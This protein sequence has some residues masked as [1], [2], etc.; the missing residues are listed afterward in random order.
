MMQEGQINVQSENIFPIIKKFLYSDNDIFLR[1]LISNAVDATEKVRKLARTGQLGGEL[2]D[3]KIEVKLD[4]E[5]KTLTISDRGVGMTQEEVEKYINQIAFSG[6]EEFAKKLEEQ[7]EKADIIGQ[8]GLGFYSAFM[9]SNK[10]EIHS[11]SYQDGAQPVYWECDGSTN[12]KIGEGERQDRGTDIVLHIDEENEEFLEENRISELLDKYCKFLPVPIKFGTKEVTKEGQEDKEESEK[13]KETVDNIINNPEPAWTKDPKELG[14]EDYKNFYRELY[15][16][17]F[18][19]PLFHIHLNVDHP[20]QLTGILYFPPLKNNLE[21]QKNRIQLYS[22]QVFV[23]DNVEQIVPEFLTLLHGVIDSPDI[24]LNVSRSYLQNDANV[25]KIS[26]HITKKVADKL[27][28]MFKNDREDFEKKWD[29][30]KVFIQYGILTDDKF[31]DRVKDVM[32]LKNIEGKYFTLDEYKDKV[33]DHQTDKNDKMVFLYTHDKDEQYNF[34]QPAQERGYDVLLMDSP[35]ASHLTTRLE[36]KEENISFARVD[37]D[38]VDN[39]IQKEESQES[40]LSEE[41][42]NEIKPVFEEQVPSENYQVQFQ[43][44]SEKDDPVVITQSEF[45]RRMKEQQATGGGGMM[46]Q[47]PEM[48]N[49]V[50]NANHPLVSRLL[51]EQDEEKK[52]EMAKQAID[53]GKLS[54]GLLKGEE[55]NRFIKRS[56]DLIGVNTPGDNG[57]GQN[58]Q[59]GNGQQKKEQEEEKEGV[60][61]EGQE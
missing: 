51:K 56:V 40:K 59:S 53:L 20:F 44:M 5:N 35:L 39:L 36:Q 3:D 16:T 47:L 23:T 30:I 54:Q 29:D 55:L 17:S 26:G 52:K 21:V 58:Q 9:V 7:G 2:G 43:P 28:E 32:L 14:E 38:T 49:L 24:P 37:A 22:N 60:K 13:E 27:K 1:E 31:F 15:P 4:S 12:Y 6:A 8:F 34:I 25:R 46:G 48:Y 45:M 11:C 41:E 18:E 50:V 61:N 10:V 42:Q 19:E 33:K 57:N